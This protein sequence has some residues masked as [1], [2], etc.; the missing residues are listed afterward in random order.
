MSNIVP[1][2]AP[3]PKK[4]P[5]ARLTNWKIEPTL[6][7]LKADV[8]AAKPVQKEHLGRIERWL[9][10]L[11]ITGPA[12]LKKVEGRSSVQPKL[13]RK[14]AEWRY[15]PLSEPFLGSGKVFTLKPTSWED[16]QACRQN[17]LLLNWQFRTKLNPLVLIDQYV[18]T[19]VDEG[20]VAVRVGWCRETKPVWVDAPVYGYFPMTDP[21]QIEALT[22]AG[23]LQETNPA[24]FNSLS[25]VIKESLRYSLEN[26]G[27]FLA[28]QIGT[29][30]V[31]QQKVLKNQPTVEVINI[32]NLLIDATCGAD[33]DKAMF[34]AY[35]SEVTKGYLRTAGYYKNI[36]AIDFG[37]SILSEPDHVATGPAEV[38]FKDD[39][40]QKIVLTEYWGLYD[41]E[42]DGYLTPIVVAWVGD[43]MVR[44]EENP[45]PDGKPPFVIVPY[46]AQ[47][48]SVY[49]QPDGEL[50][51][52][53]QKILGAVTRGIIDMMARSANAQRGM[54]KSMLDV[55]NRRKFDAGQDYEFN[56][57]VHPSN[58]V[59]EHK[60]P[61][62]PQSALHMINMMNAESESLTGVKTYDQGLT[63]ASLGPTAA[64]AKGVLG[65]TSQREM[66]ILR[67]LANGFAQ[68]GQ[69][70][71]A[72]NAVFLSEE[73]VIRVTNEKFVT[74]RRDELQGNFD[75]EVTISSA[76]EDNAKAN[77]LSFMLQTMG[78]N[79]DLS[80]TKMIMSEIARLRRMPDLAHRIE[81]FQPQPDP[82]QQEMQKLEM[83]KLRAEILKLNADAAKAHADAQLGDAKTREAHSS[84]D[85]KDLKFVEDETGTTHAREIDKLAQQAEANKD[86]KITEGILNQ[87]N[88]A[89]ADGKVDT[90]P[91]KEN[92]EQAFG[93]NQLT[94][95]GQ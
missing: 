5:L 19:C 83:E 62:I 48:R 31:K 68:I 63:G 38:N 24:E 17:E 20:T 39:S 84:A 49:G 52:D 58:G 59:V 12:K 73:E 4:A 3:G 46:L 9:N 88:G 81:Q 32:N 26:N 16:T 87:R 44:C 22:E 10:N 86:L 94:K 42:G 57:N 2:I 45:F 89:S 66:S 30:K 27:P 77:D 60:Y 23:Q 21:A 43:V 56:P 25:D 82:I 74:V 93:F 18:R 67:R 55:I 95:I 90:S 41:I 40:R 85:A 13:I 1:A 50:L 15:A 29:E 78:P 70:I 72:M 6:L 11:N 75:L 47:K 35:S 79:M 36:D 8:E 53:N 51:E 80:M 28:E 61:E 69:K 71:V 37:R 33:P 34:M 7:T 54:A 91:T 14:Q 64:G 65:A 76:E 92:I